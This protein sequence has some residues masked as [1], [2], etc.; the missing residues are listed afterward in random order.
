MTIAVFSATK[1]LCAL[2]ALVVLANI[3]VPAALAAPEITLSPATG[4]PGT[5]V[6]VKGSGFTA[7]LPVQVGFGGENVGTGHPHMNG[8]F[9]DVDFDV[10]KIPRGDVVVTATNSVG[11]S[12]SATFTVI[13]TPPVAA[14]AQ[15]T[16]EEDTATAIALA[17]SDENGDPLTFAILENPHGGVISGSASEG[18]VTYTP[19]SNF[20]GP[21]SFT[22]K[23]SDGSADSNTATVSITVGTAND[24]PVTADQG[25]TVNEDEQTSIALAA[26]DSDGDPLTF[27][28]V[29]GPS[30]GA[31]TG[32]APNLAYKPQDNYF[33][34]DSFTFKANDSRADSNISTVNIAVAAVDDP[35][36]AGSASA[37]LVEDYSTTVTLTA[38][39]PDSNSVVFAIS[40]PPDHGRLD[41][42]TQT[43]SMSATV[44]YHPNPDYS[45]SDSFTFTANDG[46]LG[47]NVATA[48]ITVSP[49]NDAPVL[50]D[51]SQ[52]L[53]QGSAT[54]TLTGT[55]PDTTA[56][57]FS[58][59]RGPT[60]GTLGAV[61][62]T[63]S[64]TAT[65]VYTP[66]D[67]QSG[68][69]SFMFKASDGSLDSNVATAS[70]TINAAAPPPQNTPP[71]PVPAPNPSPEEPQSPSRRQVDV[72]D[73]LAVQ[74]SAS[75]D[76]TIVP[77]TP[78]EPATPQAEI[79]SGSENENPPASIPSMWLVVGAIAGVG[80]AGA[81]LAYRRFWAQKPLEVPEQPVAPDPP[82]P[83]IHQTAVM[84][85]A[86]RIFSLLG[87]ERSKAARK[88]VFDV[89][90]AGAPANTR[91][92]SDR[93][94]LKEHFGQISQSV[95]SD[96][97][98]NAMFMDSFAEVA[99]KVWRALAKEEPGNPDLEPVAALGREA[100]KY[101]AEHDRGPIVV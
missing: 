89:A 38:N 41:A 54:L 53:N 25:V 81:F 67:G 33:G 77:S 74:D 101:W 51:L 44:T 7:L 47:S 26:S 1:L 13:N 78:A 12:A 48:A 75:S 66:Y 42:L 17:A 3:H 30:H 8:R 31:L 65:V 50:S 5:H 82:G 35:P 21:D 79:T 80:A 6:H 28:V 4:V 20:S 57:A 27:S 69:D 43:S 10:P 90:F 72:S 32:S 49:V 71:A 96:P 87:D 76:A 64:H 14:D 85:E 68:P 95:M 23:A 88:Q 45:G 62:N 40:S 86:R 98:L 11:D 97:L 73:T 63:G 92:E 39:D 15:V 70:L 94:L 22:F 16:A 52:S 84:N 59:V 55:D 36:S 56:L 18:A 46:T 99:I 9:D 100:E 29:S 83:A 2:A 58:I 34:S 60:K 37:T 24:P 91:Y 19:N 61:A 93:A